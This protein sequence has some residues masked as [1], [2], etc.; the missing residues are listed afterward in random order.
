MS[1]RA[2]AYLVTWAWCQAGHGNWRQICREREG[3]NRTTAERHTQ[4]RAERIA[5]GLNEERA[6]PMTRDAA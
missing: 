5:E 6:R 1:S 2:G 3:W 4:W